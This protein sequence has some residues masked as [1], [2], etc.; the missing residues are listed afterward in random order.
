MTTPYTK[1][2]AMIEHEDIRDKEGN[3]IGYISD[4]YVYITEP[5]IRKITK[6]EILSEVRTWK[7]DDGTYG[8]EDISIFIAY[9]DG[10]T[11]SSDSG[12]KTFKRQGIVGV[13]ISTPDYEMVWGG[14]RN[15]RTG[16]IEPYQTWSEDGESGAEN[17]YSGY[18]NVGRYI[19]R[20][21]V[22]FNNPNGRG[23][24]KPKT[25]IIKRSTVKK[26]NY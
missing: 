13:S 15:R 7:M 16:I 11:W 26:M 14:E 1:W 4:D 18:K 24:Y 2:G 6:K 25:E 19:V 17:S 8:D 23:G 10:K 3:L 5:D 12:E 9:N 21:K 20:R 22:T